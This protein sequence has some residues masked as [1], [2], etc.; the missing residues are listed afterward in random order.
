MIFSAVYHTRHPHRGQA[1]IYDF[2][3]DMGISEQNI[4]IRSKAISVNCF[5][6]NIAF[7]MSVLGNH[8]C[9][10]WEKDLDS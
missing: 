1:S 10:G 6:R 3:C 9:E 7:D 2:N 8:C 4:M 5:Q